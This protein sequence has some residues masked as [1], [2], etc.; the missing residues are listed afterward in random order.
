MADTQAAFIQRVTSA[1]LAAAV[2]FCLSYYGGKTGMQIVCTLALLLGLREYARIAFQDLKVPISVVASYCAI[3]VALFV[4]LF[5][6]FEYAALEFAIANIIFFTLTL[7][8][9]REKSSNENILT[10][11][12]MGSFGFIYCVL[13]PFF[14]VRLV[15]LRDGGQWFLFLLIVVF[16]GDTFAYFGGRWFG[17]HKMMPQVSPNKTWEG[18]IGGLLG[19]CVGGGV[20]AAGS[21]HEAPL[22]MVLAFCLVCGVVAQSGDL[23]VSLIK[24]VAHVKDSG[25]IMPGHG[26]I[27][28]RLDGI[29]IACPL[30]YAF[31]LYVRPF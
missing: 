29:F 4:A 26:G 22:W 19:S 16:F 10:A 25:H 28:D 20:F 15:S 30:V 27:L 21:F 9:A 13:L 3:G 17:R 6:R 5:A 18:C 7:W 12:A 24:R 14:S 2:V 1:L 11:V 31:A 8:L 23:L